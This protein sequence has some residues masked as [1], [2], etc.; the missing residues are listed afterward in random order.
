[1]GA[2]EIK[3]FDILGIKAVGIPRTILCMAQQKED[4]TIGILGSTSYCL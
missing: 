1:L 4:D 2:T 3:P